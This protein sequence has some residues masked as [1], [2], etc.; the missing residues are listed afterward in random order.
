MNRNAKTSYG[1]SRK[2]VN[3]K[4]GP[5]RS[6]NNIGGGLGMR[7]RGTNQTQSS[8]P[9]ND[10]KIKNE[11]KQARKKMEAKVEADMKKGIEYVK[12]IQAL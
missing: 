7:A 9:R 4:G 2:P 12:N 11:N 5:Q 3:Q 6:G 10:D 1:G 8:D